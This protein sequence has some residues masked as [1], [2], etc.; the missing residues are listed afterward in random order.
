M[1][2]PSGSGQYSAHSNPNITRIPCTN[3]SNAVL[4][5]STS[6]PPEIFCWDQPPPLSSS[7]VYKCLTSLVDQETQTETNV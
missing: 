6:H 2:S 5:R 1:T 4:A 3:G 7:G